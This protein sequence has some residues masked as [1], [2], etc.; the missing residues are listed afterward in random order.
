MRVC[1]AIAIVLRVPPP[2]RRPCEGKQDFVIMAL[3]HLPHGSATKKEKKRKNEALRNN[4]SQ[5]NVLVCV[6]V[7]EVEYKRFIIKLIMFNLHD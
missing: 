3:W 1:H 2:Q 7:N 5:C 4:M 6:R